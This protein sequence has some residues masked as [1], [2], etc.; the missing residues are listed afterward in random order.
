MAERT[1][2]LI[3]PDAVGKPW[4]EHVFSKN[5]EDEVV[6]LD[7][8]RA[9]DKS[10]EIINRI[11]ASGLKIV[12]QKTLRITKAQ[13]RAF[14]SHQAG[15]DDYEAR[16]DHLSSGLMVA[17]VLEGDNAIV[18]LRKLIGPADSTAARRDS[19]AAHPLNEDLWTLRASFGTDRLRNAVHGSQDEF[20]AF[21]EVDFFFPS[22]GRCVAAVCCAVAHP[23]VLPPLSLRSLIVRTPRWFQLRAHVRPHQARGCRRGQ[24]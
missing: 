19:E 20:A 13:A 18:S 23:A 17:L 11:R 6:E 16:C 15:S 14:L 4:V 3:T 22:V 10:A 8:V 5:D 9:A 21:R 1:L 24:G 7:E 2:C 12:T